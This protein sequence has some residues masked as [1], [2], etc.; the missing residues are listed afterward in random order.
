VQNYYLRWTERSVLW[1]KGEKNGGDEKGRE[2]KEWVSA[3]GEK[4]RRRGNAEQARERE[5]PRAGEVDAGAELPLVPS[6][7]LVTA[8]K[9]V[10]MAT[11]PDERHGEKM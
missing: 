7:K 5:R 6:P 9:H 2:S 1:T 4:D 8:H 3:W 11:W 10:H